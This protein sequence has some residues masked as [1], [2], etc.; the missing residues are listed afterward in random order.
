MSQ[1]TRSLRYG[2]V[3]RPTAIGTAVMRAN[4]SG[5]GWLLRARGR[6]DRWRGGALTGAPKIEL[7]RNREQ[8]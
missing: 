7:D 6:A 1:T 4:A 2:L 8:S 3:D 5:T